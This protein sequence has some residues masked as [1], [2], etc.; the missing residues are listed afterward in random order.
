M[1]PDDYDKYDSRI[2]SRKRGLLDFLKIGKRNDPDYFIFHWAGAAWACMPDGTVDRNPICIACDTQLSFIDKDT[3]ICDTC[4]KYQTKEGE[5]YF[6]IN[7]KPVSF[8]DAYLS[9][10]RRWKELL[11]KGQI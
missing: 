5:F 1:V 4:H 7:D 8:E 10:Q 2:P 6:T 9:T 3:V 11:R